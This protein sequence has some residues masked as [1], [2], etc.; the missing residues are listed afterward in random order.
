MT[1]EQLNQRFAQ[2][3]QALEALLTVTERHTEQIAVLAQVSRQNSDEIA[4]IT[5]EWEAYLR[6]MRPQ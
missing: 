2:I 4:R 3:A 5:R 6:T 1:D